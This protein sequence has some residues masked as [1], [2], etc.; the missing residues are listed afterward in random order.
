MGLIPLSSNS[1]DVRH[2]VHRFWPVFYWA[3]KDGKEVAIFGQGGGWCEVAGGTCLC[4]RQR[5]GGLFTES[6]VA[7]L[8]PGLRQCRRLAA[9]GGDL[10]FAMPGTQQPSNEATGH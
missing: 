2:S 6:G 4:S 9:A 10:R 3:R 5:R 8:L 7:S 1:V